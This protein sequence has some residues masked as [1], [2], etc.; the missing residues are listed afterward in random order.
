MYYINHKY[1]IFFIL[2]LNFNI[3]SQVDHS[4]EY[5]QK[6]SICN[7]TLNINVSTNKHF[8]SKFD[9]LLINFEVTNISSHTIGLFLK[10]IWEFNYN[11]D[12]TMLN[13][14]INYV[15]NYTPDFEIEMPFSSLNKQ[16][17]KSFEFP[18]IPGKY[19]NQLVE[20][21]QIIFGISYLPDI[22][23]VAYTRIDEDVILVNNIQILEHLKDF[24]F[25]TLHVKIK[26]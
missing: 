18:F 6:Y 23:E 19:L 20:N 11:K 9:T 24:N 4:S 26:K 15:S 10:P 1:I 13:I 3:Y 7:D 12:S 14:I 16:T 22:S 2:F 8:I 5:S 17:A 25:K 21:I